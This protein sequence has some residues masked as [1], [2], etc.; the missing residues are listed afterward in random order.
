MESKI[1]LL[2]IIVPVIGSGILLCIPKEKIQQ[3]KITG[4]W[5]GGI[6]LVLSQYLWIFFDENSERFQYKTKFLGWRET[7]VTELGVD[8]ISIY[9]ILLTTLLI[10]LCLLISWKSIKHLVKEYI[11]CFL[12][13]ESALIIVF[14]VLDLVLFYVFFE[15]ILIPMFL[16]I[17]IWG[18]RTRKIRAAYQFFLYTLLGSILMLLALISR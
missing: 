16:V 12:I 14:S 11:L 3:I 2:L 9:F 4:L 7:W 15:T 8:G 10:P 18:S 5:I 1:L 17:G 6:N 13:M